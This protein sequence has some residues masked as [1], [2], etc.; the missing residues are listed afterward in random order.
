M[1]TAE[2][3]GPH[4][5]ADYDGHGWLWE[6]HRGE[7]PKAESRRVFV[8]VSGTAFAV[9]AATLAKDTRAAIESEGRSEVERVA[10]RAD[11]PRR[12]HCTRHGCEDIVDQA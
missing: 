5:E 10:Q 1:W 6:L 7:G 8:Q 3:I 12:V 11:P 2:Q 4:N 9:A